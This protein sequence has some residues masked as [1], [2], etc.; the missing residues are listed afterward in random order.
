MLQTE[1]TQQVVNIEDAEEEGNIV[2]LDSDSG[3]DPIMFSKSGADEHTRERELKES[4]VVQ[5]PRVF[6]K[7]ENPEEEFGAGLG[8]M[9]DG[10]PI[11]EQSEFNI[12]YEEKERKAMFEN[13]YG[14]KKEEPK[15]QYGDLTKMGFGP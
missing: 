5:K 12:G 3:G 10:A 15:R 6:L 13:F 11:E 7:Q 2:C 8:G 4:K 9:D 14:K 1:L